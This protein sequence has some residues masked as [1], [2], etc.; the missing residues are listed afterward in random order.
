MNATSERKILMPATPQMVD[1]YLEAIETTRT[2]NYR[3]VF[4]SGESVIMP[5]SWSVPFD[6]WQGMPLRA[7]YDNGRF[8]LEELEEAYDE[9]AE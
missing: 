8:V 1:G 3:L 6:L 5:G 9:V 7:G 2:N 4:A